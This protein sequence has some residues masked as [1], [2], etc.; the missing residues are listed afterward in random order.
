MR[1]ILSTPRARDLLLPSQITSPHTSIPCSPYLAETP[2]KQVAFIPSTPNY[3][4]A[5]CSH[6]S[7]RAL[8]PHLN[9]TFSQLSDL[10]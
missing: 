5:V 2:Q 10:L 7:N 6:A 8:I 3:Q 4:I 1:E 9:A